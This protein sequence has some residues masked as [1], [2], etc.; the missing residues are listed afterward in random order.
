M[1]LWWSSSSLPVALA[2]V[3]LLLLPLLHPGCS[4]SAVPRKTP[5]ITT[6]KAM[7]NFT[8]TLA[9]DLRRVETALIPLRAKETELEHRF[10]R[11][12]ARTTRHGWRSTRDQQ[13]NGNKLFK[14]AQKFR[15][16]VEKLDGHFKQ[17][18]GRRLNR[19]QA[20]SLLRFR[21]D[22]VQNQITQSALV[23]KRLIELLINMI[24]CPVF[25]MD[26]LG[27]AGIYGDDVDDGDTVPQ[28]NGEDGSEYGTGIEGDYGD[29][30]EEYYYTEEAAY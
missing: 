14:D 6:L 5:E 10:A 8:S 27:G 19:V 20:R 30:G 23:Y 17:D 16:T 25:I 7:K 4:G 3:L 18:F 28:G 1:S 9:R 2:V 29:Q 21:D 24:E 26:Q 15:A 11:F 22:S 13:S 12:A